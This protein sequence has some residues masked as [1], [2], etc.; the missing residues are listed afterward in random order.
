MSAV[1][2]GIMHR[3]RM[4]CARRRM[5]RLIRRWLMLIHPCR[6][7]I[8]RRRM[9]HSRRIVCSAVCVLRWGRQIVGTAATR[10]WAHRGSGQVL[11]VITA[12]SMFT[13]LGIRACRAVHARVICLV[14]RLLHLETVISVGLGAQAVCGRGAVVILVDLAMNHRIGS[15][16]I[17]VSSRSGIVDWGSLSAVRG[18]IGREIDGLGMVATRHRI[19]REMVLCMRVR[20]MRVVVVRMLHAFVVMDVQVLA[21]ESATRG[22]VPYRACRMGDL[23]VCTVVIRTVAA[24]R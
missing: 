5:P 20:M 4:R 17:S 2:S 12:Q 9:M 18:R 15:V 11:T 8:R 10:R 14:F 16:G 24:V 23:F 3:L 21:R 13:R 6:R 7:L 22:R 19:D 1:R